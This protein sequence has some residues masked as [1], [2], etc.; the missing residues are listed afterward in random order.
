VLG[1]A[2]TRVDGDEHGWAASRWAS[3]AAAV[4]VAEAREVDSGDASGLLCKPSGV[5][6]GLV[7][8]EGVEDGLLVYWVVGDERDGI[9]LRGHEFFEDGAARV[10][11]YDGSLTHEVGRLDLFDFAG[12]GWL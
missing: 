11:L 10:M 4:P 9:R 6:D 2:R 7:F 8:G 3:F 12:Q 5:D 1:Q